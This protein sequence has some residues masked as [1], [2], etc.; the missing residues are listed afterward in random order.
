MI[1][2]RF[3]PG[4]WSFGR[5]SWLWKLNPSAALRITG[6]GTTDCATGNSRLSVG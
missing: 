2:G 5:K 6:S 1:A 3:S 4:F